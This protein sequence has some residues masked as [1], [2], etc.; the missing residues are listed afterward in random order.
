MSSEPPPARVGAA[1][2]ALLLRG[3]IEAGR[4]SPAERLPPERALAET[5]GVARG[6]VREAL[7]RLSEQGL[8]HIRRGSGAYVAAQTP[9]SNGAEIE[10]A[11]P[12][13][14]M[15]ARFALEP[16]I[17]RLAVLRARRADLD[18][19]ELLLIQMEAES[20][21][22]AAFSEIDAEFH[23]FLARLSGNSLLTWMIGH[24]SDVRNQTPWAQMRSLT[25][26]PQIIARYNIEHRAIIEAI[27]QCEPEAAA[28]RM[29]D[30]LETARQTL[31]RASST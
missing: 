4:H 30:H 31:Y 28:A 25:L 13:E 10:S 16:H 6:T 26:N 5:Y 22:A 7:K 15:E 9:M 21:D 12:L 14:L 18:K 27:R 24:I 11:S 17:C 29:K 19:A 23:A 2:V 1:E 20:D 3:A 8:I